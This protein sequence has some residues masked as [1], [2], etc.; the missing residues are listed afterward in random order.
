[1]RDAE[2][3]EAG[4]ASPSVVIVIASPF[5]RR[6]KQSTSLRRAK[7]E[8]ILYWIVRIPFEIASLTA[9]VRND[10]G[11]DYRSDSEARSSPTRA[12][13]NRAKYLNDILCRFKFCLNLLVLW[14]LL[15]YGGRG[16]RPNNI[17]KLR[18]LW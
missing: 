6:A 11:E 1:V 13:H 16:A 14:K 7:P 5:L 4:T 12:H 18:I 9:F 8:A 2:G 3:G 10:E 15:S 17:K